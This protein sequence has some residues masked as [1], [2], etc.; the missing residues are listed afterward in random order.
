VK[1][2]LQALVIIYNGM[3][4]IYIYMGVEILIF[5]NFFL[6]LFISK[7]NKVLFIFSNRYKN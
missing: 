2:K 3:F 5:F 1:D 6:F 7:Y 4:D